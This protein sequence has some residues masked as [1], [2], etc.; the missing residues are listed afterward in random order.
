MGRIVSIVVD[1][2]GAVGFFCLSYQLFHPPIE[3]FGMWCIAIILVSTAL[4]CIVHAI[5]K[6]VG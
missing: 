2:G 3:T 6:A 5:E 1:L 4:G